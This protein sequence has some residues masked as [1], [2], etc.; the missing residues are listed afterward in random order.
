MKFDI[1]VTMFPYSRGKLYSSVSLYCI[2]N[3]KDQRHKRECL[4]S[5]Q[6]L[7]QKACLSRKA[8]SFMMFMFWKTRC[9]HW[10]WLYQFVFS[11]CRGNYQALFAPDISYLF[12]IVTVHRYFHDFW[13]CTDYRI[14]NF[15][16]SMG[17][18]LTD[19]SQICRDDYFNDIVLQKL[20]ANHTADNWWN[21]GHS[22]KPREDAWNS[23]CN[24]DCFLP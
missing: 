21:F 23:F 7:F 4:F 15:A 5:H 24:R 16:T 22:R 6:R 1:S 10:W 12:P 11:F 2:I 17:W 13:S 20:L 3:L 8:Y 9:K 18:L 19:K 14:A